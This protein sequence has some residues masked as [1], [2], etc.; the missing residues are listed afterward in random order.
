MQLLSRIVLLAFAGACLAQQEANK[1][2]IFRPADESILQSGTVQ[3]VARV[4]GQDKLLVD[5]KPVPVKQPAPTALVADLELT[6]GMHEL[7]LESGPK[8]RVFVPGGSAKAPDG[9][10]PFRPH[11]PAAQCDTCHSVTDGAWAMKNAV[12]A[13]SCATCHDL[14]SFPKSHTHTVEVLEECQ[15]CHQPHG[16]KASFHLKFDKETACKQCHG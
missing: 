7:A 13:E 10:Q 11:P 9:W 8:V 14:K 1:P 12:T 2:E 5:G 16:S 4:S 3:V 15:L 6:A